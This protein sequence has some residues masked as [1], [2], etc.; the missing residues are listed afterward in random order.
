MLWSP[1]RS[2]SFRIARADKVSFHGTI[3]VPD[4]IRDLGLRTKIVLV[5]LDPGSSPGRCLSCAT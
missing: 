3:D 4:L 5:A 2:G 1:W